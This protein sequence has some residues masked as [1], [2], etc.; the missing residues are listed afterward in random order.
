MTALRTLGLVLVAAWVGIMAFFS[1]VAAPALFG[2]LDRATAG[3]LVA[4]L[5]P[6]YYRWGLVL[7]GAAALALLGSA[8]GGGAGRRRAGLGA[9]LAAVMVGLLAWALLVT[10]PEATAARR[11]RHDGRFAAAHR[12][13]V[14]L[15]VL[16]L[17]CGLLL[18]A[19]VD[20]RAGRRTT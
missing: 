6:P 5:L 19:V 3:D 10:L 9:A 12:S 1:F 15:N 18:L 4:G 2:T 7:C 20:P 13:A 11:E 14:T 16:T 8:A 17:A